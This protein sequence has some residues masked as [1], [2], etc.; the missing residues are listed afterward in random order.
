M[1]SK[2]KFWILLVILSSLFTQ[3]AVADLVAHWKFDEG[4]GTTAIDS[5]GNGND[6][7]L[8]GDLQW[9]PGQLG[10][11][12]EGNGT[13]DIIRVAHADSLDI[14]DAVTVSLWLY[15]GTP[16]DQPISKGEWN[17]SY[18]IRLD[19]AGGRLRQVNWRGRGPASPAPGWDSGCL[20]SARNRTRSANRRRS[21][22]GLDEWRV[23]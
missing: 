2:S 7:T 6:G 1:P 9:V 8:E 19:D 14:S 16:P 18:G 17:A 15:G 11:A 21:D 12:L 13:S 20:E 3:L 22:R 4:A 10:G 5:S 23:D